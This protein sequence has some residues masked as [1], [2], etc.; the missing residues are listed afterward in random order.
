[1]HSQLETLEKS[2]GK[3]HAGDAEPLPLRA[4]RCACSLVPFS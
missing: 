3:L 2:W 4:P 1:M